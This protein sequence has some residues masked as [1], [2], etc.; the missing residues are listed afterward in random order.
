M[1]LTA[2]AF[3]V[4]RDLA[5]VTPADALAAVWVAHT[6]SGGGV[7]PTMAGLSLAGG[8][9]N[10][11]SGL[12][13]L[14]KTDASTRLWLDAISSL[15]LV[16]G[17]PAGLIV[18]E[19][20][21][22]AREDGGH[23]LAGLQ[24]VLAI[25]IGED[26]API[27]QRIQHLLNV[28]TNSRDS[29]IE[30][31]QHGD[32]KRFTLRDH[33]LP[34][35]AEITWGQVDD[36]YLIAVGRGAFERIERT[37]LGH[38][39]KNR[40]VKGLAPSLASNPWFLEAFEKT[41]GGKAEFVCYLDFDAIRRPA[42]PQ[43]KMKINRVQI[44]LHLS[45]VDQ[46]LWTVRK[47]DRSVELYGF[48]RRFGQDIF[49]PL[50]SSRLLAGRE[51]SLIPHESTIFMA[52]EGDP[53]KIVEGACRAV[54][55]SKSPH[56]Q[57]SLKQFW[58]WVQKESGVDIYADVIDQLGDAVIIHDYPLH[59]F[60]LPVARTIVVPVKGDPDVLR[61]SIDRLMSFAQKH[62]PPDGMFQLAQEPDGIW[63]IRY[64]LN[65][66]GVT[67]AGRWLIISFT[68]EA[69]RKNVLFLRSRAGS[70][71]S[72]KQGAAS[73]AACPAKTPRARPSAL[74]GR[75]PLHN[76]IDPR[77]PIRKLQSKPRVGQGLDETCIDRG[78]SARTLRVVEIPQEPYPPPCIE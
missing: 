55:F 46:G 14:T 21:A 70:S 54:L 60:R 52:V 13:L 28:H 63:H 36:W 9:L 53:H 74:G 57:E 75:R 76:A 33:R 42:D 24:A 30:S 49:R 51:L 37:V 3:A 26:T 44:A 8:F 58:R 10:Q 6:A 32:R 41:E 39:S 66:P 16:L 69:V 20:G 68:P 62:V 35:W 50:A 45:G 27:N 47:E 31:T 22:T 2:N 77:I 78:A 38:H 65:G 40:D 18:L 25:R 48:Y 5:E 1:L 64:V 12:G 34:A 72:K 17:H 59:A 19:Y 56:G 71:F 61:S 43:L 73:G 23:Q 4:P 11:A 15:P 7:S 67:V 29:T